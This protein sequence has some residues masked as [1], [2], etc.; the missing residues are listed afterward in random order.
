MGKL[1]LMNYILIL[2][3]LGLT[4][5][6]GARAPHRSLPSLELQWSHEASA[7]TSVPQRH[8]LFEKEMGYAG[9]ARL[10]PLAQVKRYELEE[11]YENCAS[12]V[13]KIWSS[14]KDIQGWMALQ[15]TQCLVAQLKFSSVKD[16]KLYP[17][18]WA[19]LLKQGDW[20][21]LGPWSEDLIK[22]WSEFAQLI[23]K[24]ASFPVAFRAEVAEA[25]RRYTETL[26][27]SDRQDLYKII[28]EDLRMNGHSE[29]AQAIGLREGL[30]KV[31][32]KMVE[33]KMNDKTEREDAGIKT[34]TEEDELFGRFLELIKQNQLAGATELAV[35]LL[36]R[37]PNGKNASSVQEKLFQ[38]YFNMWDAA[39]GSEQQAQVERCLDL[40]KAIHSSRL[41]EWAKSAHRRAD[42]Q[43]AY[44]L[45][46]YALADEE[47]SADGASLLFI[48]G[49][50]AYFLGKYREAVGFFD[51]LIE[52]HSGYS[53]FWE[54][55]FRRAM[56]FIRLGDELKAEDAFGELW[57]APEN[58]TYSLSSLY[59][60][61]RLKQKR[62]AN[63]DEWM[64]PMQERFAL[65]YYG[66]KL[67]AESNRQKVVLPQETAAIRLQRQWILTS[68]EKAQ[69]S[70]VQ[71]LAT[72]GWY[73]A[74]QGEI[75][76]LVSGS[77]INGDPELKFLWAQKLVQIFSFPQ[78]LRVMNELSDVEPRWRKA[79]Y[80]KT[81]FPKPLEHIVQAEAQK[82]ELN[83]LL[84]FSLMRQ[85]SAFLLGATSRSQAKGLMQLIPA[86][87][88]E[89]AQDLRIKNFD[90]DQMYHPIVN[91]KFG[92]YYLAKV[93][94]QFGGNV[95]VGLA[96]YN[97]GPQRLKRFFEARPEVENAAL[98]SQEDPWSDLW[99]EELPW[100]ETN[101][102]VKSILRNRVI[103][104]ALEQGSFDWPVPIWKD[105]FFGTKNGTKKVSRAGRDSSQRWKR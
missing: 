70:R 10:A 81:V 69:W 89:V 77:M 24:D 22:I 45:A 99:I 63:V 74:A 58:K 62:K 7:A 51:R 52:R 6:A 91:I 79:Q 102:Y 82:N 86:T 68:T 4:Q 8:W 66:L 15:G 16:K 47:K 59:W 38:S 54:T 36:D 103:Y 80:L 67:N 73:V 83:P 93:I 94:R 87:A 72:A 92:T 85:E 34:M 65:T 101:L 43:G 13:L 48:A 30:V 3:N 23:L 40:A 55:K 97:A 64:A 2:V 25:W 41:I 9:P 50:S 32:E 27:R 44:T 26:N 20:V 12:Q 104:Q 71:D 14:Y 35:Q 53:D 105:L 46:K 96:A 95:S 98:L 61:I 60:L 100:L 78:A 1:M 33:K 84:V 17:R 37:Y 18:W 11:K 5:A 31:P 39:P 75:N 42:F 19:H 76:N 56:A 88:N 28:I 90:S 57:L 49:R 29:L 21:L